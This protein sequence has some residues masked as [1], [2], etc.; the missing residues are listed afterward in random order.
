MEC[1]RVTDEWLYKYMSI[2]DEAI[3]RELEKTTDYEY[4]FSDK[5]ES[6][7]EKLVWEETHPWISEFYRQSKRAAILLLCIISAIFL[8]SMTVQAYRTKFFETI[9]NSLEDS[10]LYSYFVDEK[11]DNFHCSEPEYIPVGYQEIDRVIVDRLFSITYANDDGELIIWDQMLIQ[12]GGNLVVD[13][14]YDTQVV[15]EINGDNAIISLYSDGYVGAYY[16]HAEYVY[17]LSAD[18]LSIEELCSM[19]ESV[20]FN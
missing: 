16:E 20:K 8:L 12:D 10:I 13:T 9:K 4:Q 11:Q 5:F 19:I 17:I 14:E 7:M 2:V 3:I 6:K 15:K 1:I 18:K